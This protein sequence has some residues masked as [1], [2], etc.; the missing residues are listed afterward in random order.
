[1]SDASIGYCE[2]CKHVLYDCVC[3]EGVCCDCGCDLSREEIACGRDMC[4]ECYCWH[5]D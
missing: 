3:N 2:Q 5:Q 4:F 1:M